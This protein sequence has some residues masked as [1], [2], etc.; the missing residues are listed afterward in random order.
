MVYCRSME[1]EKGRMSDLQIVPSVADGKVTGLVSSTDIVDFDNDVI[2][3]DEM[4]TLMESFMKDFHEG[5]ATINLNHSEESGAEFYKT[6][7]GIPIWMQKVDQG[8]GIMPMM[9]VQVTDPDALRY[10][11]Q[12]GANG[13]SVGFNTPVKFEMSLD[14]NGNPLRNLKGN[15]LKEISILA[16]FKK[17]GS[18]V[19]PA[20][21]RAQIV[22]TKNIK[23]GTNIM[24]ELLKK[25][26]AFITKFGGDEK[27]AKTLSVDDV[28]KMIKEAQVADAT[29]A[30]SK[31]E[32]EKLEKSI[33]ELKA[34]LA[35]KS[36]QKSPEEIA[37]ELTA[38]IEKEKAELEAQTKS[39]KERADKLEKAIK[40]TGKP[41]ENEGQ[42]MTFEN[43]SIKSHFPKDE[44]VQVLDENELREVK[45]ISDLAKS[46]KLEFREAFRAYHKSR[47]ESGIP[48]QHGIKSSS[49]KAG[50]LTTLEINPSISMALQGY[51]QTGGLILPEILPD[52]PVPSERVL[53]PTRPKDN[54]V[55][56]SMKRGVRGPSNQIRPTEGATNTYVLD[57]YDAAYP[58]DYRELESAAP[59]WDLE[60]FAAE[61]AMDS[62]LLATEVVGA[63][64]LQDATKYATGMTG[65]PS[66]KW[67]DTNNVQIDI[68]GDLFAANLKFRQQNGRNATDIVIPM[69]VWNYVVR[70]NNLRNVVKFTVPG[71]IISEQWLISVLWK[72]LERVHIGVSAYLD[73]VTSTTF[74]DVWTNT[75]ILFQQPSNPNLY[76]PA[77]GFNLVKQGYPVADSY[78]DPQAPGKVTFWRGTKIQLPVM[79]GQESGTTRAYLMT[80][81]IA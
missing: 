79:V 62:I 2:E 41:K 20:N 49:I 58:V 81:V 32:K 34:Q 33:E 74:T 29:V 38:G 61:V 63:T 3:P 36:A 22:A 69:D 30:M 7:I 72:G 76:S 75:V 9:T 56:Y 8:T 4:Q 23:Q 67:S 53:L 45:E 48:Y 39:L 37:A 15:T 5:K 66:W 65:V 46:H 24:D 11:Q 47:H 77:L 13:I 57:E 80:G 50:R 31:E 59:V 43:N 10:I 40:S 64:L 14:E 78:G 54:V 1:N 27:I 21:P 60:L 28:Q 19:M 42:D 6:D 18:K 68:L 12:N 25:L 17:D 52:L 71:G 26:D 73:K 51:K 44:R 55:Y 16:G 70:D 35:A